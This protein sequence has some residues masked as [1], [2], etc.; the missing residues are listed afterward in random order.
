MDQWG[1]A[2]RFKIAFITAWASPSNTTLSKTS[3]RANLAASRAAFD[4]AQIGLLGHSSWVW[5]TIMEPLL[6]IQSTEHF[7]HHLSKLQ[8]CIKVNF[9]PSKRRRLPWGGILFFL[10]GHCQAC[11]CCINTLFIWLKSLTEYTDWLPHTA[12]FLFIQIWSQRTAAKILDSIASP[13]C[14]LKI[15]LGSINTFIHRSIFIS[16]KPFMFRDQVEFAQTWTV[17]GSIWRCVQWFLSLPQKLD[18]TSLE[19][20]IFY[21]GSPKQEVIS[22]LFSKEGALTSPIF[23]FSKTSS[24]QFLASAFNELLFFCIINL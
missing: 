4:S 8:C 5:A 9:D 19:L 21:S 20:E 18:N 22:I 3:R 16:L 15:S 17:W 23:C 13:A 6:C 11:L 2:D 1:V 12:L 10:K 14:I 24:I 7:Q